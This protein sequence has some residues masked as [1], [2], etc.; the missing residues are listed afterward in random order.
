MT[1]TEMLEWSRR[2]RPK[3]F[4]RLQNPKAHFQALWEEIEEAVETRA[5]AVARSAAE[6]PSAARQAE[7]EILRE[8]LLDLAEPTEPLDRHGAYPMDMPGDPLED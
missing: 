6:Y 2:F 7:S 8:R 1:P 3:A 4:A 5:C